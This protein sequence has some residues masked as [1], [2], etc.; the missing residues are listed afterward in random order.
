MRPLCPDDWETIYAVASDPEIWAKHPSHDRWQE[1]VFRQFFAEGMVRGGALAI[2]DKASGE[3]IG[4]SQF[5]QPDPDHPDEI[6][7]GWSFLAR[8]YW[9][10]GYNAE[11]KSLMLAHALAHYERAIFQVG[12]DNVISRRAMENIGGKLTGRTRNFER[13]G[14]MVRHVIFE[15]T[16]ESFARGPLAG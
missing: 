5:A 16:R 7:I 1:P 3:L 13:G 15:I 14:V 10:R 9:G 12:E 4:S 2:M 11:F 8:R 6:E